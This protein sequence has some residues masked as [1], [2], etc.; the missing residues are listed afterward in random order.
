MRGKRSTR[1]RR[2]R[3]I[4]TPSSGTPESRRSA[5]AASCSQRAIVSRRTRPDG[6]T[7]PSPARARSV[8]TRP[9]V[10]GATS[11]V[12]CTARTLASGR[13]GSEASA[14][15][16]AA[17]E[18]RYSASSSRR[19]NA[20]G[21]DDLAAG[22]AH[23]RGEPA[24]G[25]HH[26][27]RARIGMAGDE[28]GDVV[29]GG[30]APRRAARTAPRRASR[31]RRRA[32]ARRRSPSPARRARRRTSPGAR[33]AAAARRGRSRHQ[34]SGREPMTLLPSTIHSAIRRT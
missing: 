26:G 19:R 18:R 4:H 20:P 34:P 33:P 10:G 14:V 29:V 32:R 21:A 5:K 31:R 3:T 15:V 23:A 6:A 9:S 30:V 27:Q 12:S 8:K 28:R 2:R 11:S 17:V 13:P 24:V 7:S 22:V 25:G 16:T 1:R